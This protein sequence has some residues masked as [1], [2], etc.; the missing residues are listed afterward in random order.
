LIEVTIVVA[1]NTLHG[2]YDTHLASHELGDD[3]VTAQWIVTVRSKLPTKLFTN[4]AA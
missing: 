2:Y 3:D 1:C 4:S